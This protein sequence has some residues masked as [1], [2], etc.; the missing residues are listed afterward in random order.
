MPLYDYRCKSCRHELEAL[1]G[2]NEAP[3]TDCP[4]CGAASLEKV[5]SAPAFSFKGGGWYKDLYS[6]PDAAKKS[7]EKSESG[8]DKSAAKT[9]EKPAEGGKKAEST[10]KPAA[11]TSA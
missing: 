1:Q 11:P 8:G 5:P 3:L 10:A 7:A 4:E 6:S 9:S 2:I